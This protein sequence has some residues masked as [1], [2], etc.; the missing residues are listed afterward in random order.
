MNSP[1]SM[2]VF[3]GGAMIHKATSARIQ[4]TSSGRQWRETNRP[5]RSNMFTSQN[6]RGNGLAGIQRR[7]TRC[8]ISAGA[9]AVWPA[10]AQQFRSCPAPGGHSEH[11]R[12]EFLI[13]KQV[14]TRRRPPNG[15]KAPGV[16]NLL[17]ALKPVLVAAQ[18]ACIAQTWDWARKVRKSHSSLHAIPGWSQH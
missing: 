15:R 16:E 8:E 1:S 17:S 3:K 9:A 14:S 10:N 5:R 12:P 11:D 6:S 13:R 2:T 18:P 4:P 7:Q